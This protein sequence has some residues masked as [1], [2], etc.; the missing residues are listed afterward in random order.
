MKIT[1]YSPEPPYTNGYNIKA[2]KKSI[3]NA[4]NSIRLMYDFSEDEIWY[5]LGDTE[6]SKFENGKCE[7]NLPKWKIDAVQGLGLK[8]A[9]STQN[10]WSYNYSQQ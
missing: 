3:C 4:N 6:Y 2:E 9:T 8:N 10:K 5:I 7:F 1:I